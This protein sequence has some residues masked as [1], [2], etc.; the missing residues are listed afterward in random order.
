[1]STK[2]FKRDLDE[3]LLQYY[4]YLELGETDE[5]TRVINNY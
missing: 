4:E 3:Q 5:Q 1:M 2:S